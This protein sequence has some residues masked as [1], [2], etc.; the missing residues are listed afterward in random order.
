MGNRYGHP[1][2]ETLDTLEEAG[3][4]VYRTDISGSIVALSDGETITITTQQ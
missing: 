3:V 1:N 2:E 4:E